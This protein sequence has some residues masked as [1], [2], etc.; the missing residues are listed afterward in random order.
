MQRRLCAAILS[1]QTVVL[2]LT[3]PVLIAI[4]DVPVALGLG[5]GLGLA[6][7]C[8]L[9]AGLLRHRWAYAAGWGIQVAAVAL[10]F[11][12]PD[13]L[14]LGAIFFAL[15]ATAYILGAKIERERA[16]WQR[17]GRYP[18]QAGSQP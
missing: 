8:L 6:L 12:I 17:T 10:S 4:A 7:A 13:M 5:I 2:G 14:V 11:L 16:E 18:G 15:W 9:V 3:T 1:L